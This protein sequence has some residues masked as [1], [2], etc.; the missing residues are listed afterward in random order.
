MMKGLGWATFVSKE[1]DVT[2]QER[3]S[4]FKKTIVRD[5]ITYTR[6][7]RPEYKSRAARRDDVVY[8]L[9]IVASD[10]EN[11]ISDLE[12]LGTE[13]EDLKI[14][15][16]DLDSAYADFQDE[17]DSVD[18]AERRLDILDGKKEIQELLEQLAEQIK[19]IVEGLP[20]EIDFSDAEELREELQSWFDNLPEQFQGADKGQ[21]LEEAISGLDDAIG[22]LENFSL[23]VSHEDEDLIASIQEQLDSLQAGIEALENVDFPGMY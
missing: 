20:T 7:K 12:S 16:E 2:I 23:T 10:L 18:D 3:C 19:S 22:E 13:I 17:G 14:D 11:A 1:G 9:Q 8:Q 21:Q 5:G 15:L 6:V 4:N